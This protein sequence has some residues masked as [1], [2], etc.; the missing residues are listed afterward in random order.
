MCAAKKM[1]LDVREVM[2]AAADTEAAR[3]MLISVCVYYDA[4]SPAELV[5]LVR[6][7]FD[8]RARNATVRVVPYEAGAS[9]MLPEADLAVLVAGLSSETGKLAN[10]IRA[11][12]IPVLTVT[13][14]PFI[15]KEQARATGWALLEEDVVHPETSIDGGALPPTSDFNQEPYPLTIDRQESLL[16]RMGAWVVDT[17]REK[18]LAFAL[19]FGF[20]RRPLSVEFVNATAMQN[21]GIGLVVVIPGADMPVM[22]LNQAKMVLQIAAAYDQKLGK[23]RIGELVAVVG[24]GFA[25]RAVA[26]QVVAAVPG[27]GWAVKA[28]IGYG[29]TVAMG[30]AAIAYFEKLVG[31]GA[32]VADAMAAARIEAARVQAAVKSADNPV[33]AARAAVSTVLVDAASGAARAVKGAVPRLRN[34]VVDVCET[35]N[36]SPIDVGKRLLGHV[37]SARKSD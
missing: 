29:G 23:E 7:A 3:S 18:R 15:V 31:E 33:A 4:Q 35:S 12:G 36:V 37:T 14:M 17:F 24:G 10:D 1:P 27:F 28:G 13:T 8:T 30:Y 22:T 19:A 26:R 32:S 20:V 6:H 25:C 11:L 34:A 2:K 16:G 9:M 21:A 5:E